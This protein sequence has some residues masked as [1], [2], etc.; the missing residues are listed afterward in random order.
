MNPAVLISIRP[1]WVELIAAGEKTAELRKSEPGIPTPFTC[2]VYQTKAKWLYDFL[3]SRGMNELADRLARGLGKVVGEFT[4]DSVI[5]SE[6]VY[7]H[8]DPHY[9]PGPREFYWPWVD[10]EAVCLKFGEVLDYG[11][12]KPLFSWHISELQIYD[13]PKSLHKFK[14]FVDKPGQYGFF[15]IERAPQSWCYVQKVED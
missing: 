5:R 14:R 8:D 6:Y 12:K 7:D 3:L 1:Q 13:E 4:C 10:L 15:Y 11:D 2:Y 9:N